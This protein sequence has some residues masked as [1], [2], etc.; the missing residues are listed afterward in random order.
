MEALARFPGVVDDRLGVVV[1][2]CVVVVLVVE[3]CVVVV[4]LVLE[5]VVFIV[6][7]V[8]VEPLKVDVLVV[9][10]TQMPERQVP[11]N[12]EA[13][14]WQSVPLL[15]G[16]AKEHLPCTQTPR[17]KQ[18]PCEQGVTSAAAVQSETR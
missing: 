2:L 15:T 12:P 1:D 9:G 4:E 10:T 17:E 16:C 13:G 11:F 6:D 14:S 18:G 7:D 5:V 8:V 3:V